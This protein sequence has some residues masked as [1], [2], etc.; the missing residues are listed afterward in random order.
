MGA[1]Q[2]G[3]YFEDLFTP[4]YVVKAED[5]DDLIASI[6]SIA[7]PDLSEITDAI[8]DL[9]DSKVDKVDGHSL[10]A[11]TD[12]VAINESITALE[13]DKVDKVDGKSLVLDT[14]ITKLAS[15]SNHYRGTYLTIEALQAAV[16]TANPGDEALVDGGDGIPALKYFWDI[17]EGWIPASPV[18]GAK[19][20]L[21]G[22]DEDAPVT[23]DLAVE[24]EVKLVSSEDPNNFIQLRTLQDFGGTD[25]NMLK[26]AAALIQLVIPGSY[27]R[28]S[29]LFGF[30]VRASNNDTEDPWYATLNFTQEDE[31][32]S[33]GLIIS[34]DGP[35]MS[36]IFNMNQTGITFSVTKPDSSIAFSIASNGLFVSGTSPDGNYSISSST[37][38]YGMESEKNLIE[39]YRPTP[40]SIDG[41]TSIYCYDKSDVV[42]RLVIDPRG[43]VLQDVGMG[44]RIKTGGTSAKMGRSTL[45]AGTVTV[46]NITVNSTTSYIQLTRSTAG[47]TLGHLSYTIINA[48]SFT[49]TSNSATDT[50]VIIWQISDA[51]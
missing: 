37:D 21:E 12:L 32:G 29:E 36:L 25:V 10:I 23:G 15:M 4:G 8:D 1:I 49:I 11:D 47:G 19:I 17:D 16:P 51:S 3:Q 31:L 40:G 20:P 24:D 6:P 5:L 26:I 41:G 22:T 27:F 30:E 2:T 18:S 14:E 50:S 45:V 28:F 44:L 48:T 42:K 34:S 9:N 33:G 35:D 39:S 13:E 43:L 38:G 46:S 7:A